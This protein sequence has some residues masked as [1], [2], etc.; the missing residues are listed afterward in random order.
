MPAS[1]RSVAG[2]LGDFCRG[3]LLRVVVRVPSEDTCRALQPGVQF[4]LVSGGAVV[5]AVVTMLGRQVRLI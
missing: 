5:M 3:H 4:P 2:G 1:G